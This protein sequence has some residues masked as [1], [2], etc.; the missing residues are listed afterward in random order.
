MNI[1]FFFLL[2]L[3]FSPAIFF[4]IPLFF[5]VAVCLSLSLISLCSLESFKEKPFEKIG[6]PRSKKKRKKSLSSMFAFGVM[7]F[8][9]VGHLF[10]FSSSSNRNRI[11]DFSRFNWPHDATTPSIGVGVIKKYFDRSFL[12]RFSLDFS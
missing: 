3:S 2:L 10:F 8:P 4:S 1:Y 11:N 7:R 5:S 6:E 12:T 9:C